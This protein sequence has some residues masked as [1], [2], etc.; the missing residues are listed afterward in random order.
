MAFRWC[1]IWPSHSFTDAIRMGRGRPGRVG[2]CNCAGAPCASCQLPPD[3]AGLS[4]PLSW[5]AARGTSISNADRIEFSNQETSTDRA[6]SGGQT[7]DGL[8]IHQIS[9]PACLLRPPLSP[10]HASP[11]RVIRTRSG[12]MPSSPAAPLEP[13]RT[14]VYAPPN[15]FLTVFPLCLPWTTTRMTPCSTTSSAR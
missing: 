3:A 4:N 13:G 11:S 8:G 7:A 15:P 9:D 6:P 12:R 14:E 2:P 5:P 10:P 1:A